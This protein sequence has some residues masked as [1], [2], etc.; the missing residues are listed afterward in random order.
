MEKVQVIPPPKDV[1]PQILTWKGATVL[2]KMESVSE[3]WVTPADWVNPS[4]MLSRSQ[5]LILFVGNLGY[6]RP[7]RTML[8]SLKF[9]KCI[10]SWV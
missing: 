9:S 1:D 7:Q 3:L 10:D 2:G 5:Y 8:L 6:A 4:F